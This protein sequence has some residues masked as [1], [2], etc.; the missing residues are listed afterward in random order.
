M[1]DEDTQKLAEALKQVLTQEEIWTLFPL[2]LK[3]ELAGLRVTIG[4]YV[5]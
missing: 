3:L 5:A 2:I 4:G 1:H